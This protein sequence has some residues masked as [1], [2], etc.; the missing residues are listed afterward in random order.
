MALVD[1]LTQQHD[2]ASE[3]LSQDQ[4]RYKQ[5]KA[6]YNSYFPAIHLVE[7]AAVPIIKSRPKRTLI[8]M[9]ATFVA[10]IVSL[11]G[12]L[13]LQLSK[14]VKWRTFFDD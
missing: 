10:F 4:E 6:A 3:Q 7:E 13:L 11:I 2:E 8:V 14:D 1:V 5:I 9:A 12:V